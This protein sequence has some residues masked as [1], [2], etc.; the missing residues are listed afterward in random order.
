MIRGSNQRLQNPEIKGKIVWK[1][2]NRRTHLSIYKLY[3]CVR[4]LTYIGE[5][6]PFKK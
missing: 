2:N 5:G 6:V 1:N 4:I 3:A